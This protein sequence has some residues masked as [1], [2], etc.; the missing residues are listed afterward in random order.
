[1]F[2]NLILSSRRILKY[3]VI[4]LLT[5]FPSYLTASGEIEVKDV[6]YW[7]SPDYTRVVVDLTGTVEFSKNRISN[8]DRLYFDLMNTTIAR[9]IKTSL[10]VGDGILKIV[11]A[12]QFKPN[13]VRVVL[14]LEE[15]ADFNVFILDGPA[16]LIIDVRGKEKM[17]RTDAAIA[18]RRIVIDP[19]HGGHDPGAVG[20]KGLYEKDVVLDVALKLKEILLSNPLNEVILTRETDV[21]LSLEKRTAIANKKNADL[22]VSIHA[23][24]S[25]RRTAKGVETYLLNWADDEEAMRVAARENAISLNKMKAIN[26]QM[27]MDVL[28]IIKSDLMRQNKRDESIKLA[29]YIQK[30]IVSTLNNNREN[31]LDLGIKQALF[32]VLFGARMPSVLVEVSFISNPE[33]ERLLSSD[34]YRM[35]IAEAIAGGLNKYIT[36]I[37]TVQ[38]VA[39]FRS[40]K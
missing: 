16:R 10:P 27:Q 35:Q 25:P 23:N 34:Y 12:G 13:I 15:I 32:Y 22:F 2:L 30:S 17:K 11:R 26:R 3:A 39:E 6:R 4:L 14:D 9:E 36:I 8:P 7:S 18:K 21:F 40:N 5:F 1:M 37:P 38:K 31:T 19:G 33:E 28:D 24:A 20:L 29:H